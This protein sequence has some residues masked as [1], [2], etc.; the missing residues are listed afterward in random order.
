MPA[1]LPAGILRRVSSL[2]TRPAPGAVGAR[3][4]RPVLVVGSALADLILAVPDLPR[5]G[6]HTWAEP[7]AESNGGTG[8]NVLRAVAALGTV[9][10][11]ALAVGSGLRGERIAQE[12]RALGAALPDGAPSLLPLHPGDNGLCL[13]LLTPDGERTFV[14]TPGCEMDWSAP[15]LAA[16]DDVLASAP[17][18]APLRPVVYASGFQLLARGH[19]LMT[20]LEGRDA[21]VVVD[22]GGRVADLAA[23][24]ALRRR[25]LARTD[26]LA[27]NEEEADTL[28]AAD[29]GAPATAPERLDALAR[30][31]TATGTDVVLRQGAEG[32]TWVPAD[33][34]GVLSA[35]AVPV[36]VVDTDGAGDAHTAGV[37]VG[38]A[39]SLPPAQMLALAN[40]SAARVVA[41]RG[42]QGL[43]A[44]DA[45]GGAQKAETTR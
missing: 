1:R 11:S 39:R 4:E 41:G 35:P 37:L 9:P 31:A 3:D 44:R 5:R 22:P 8:L 13:T 18:A 26:V 21:T 32:A 24:A 23:D 25:L 19:H 20:W 42:P 2:R 38:L 34:T 30:L 40:A 14:T 27:A 45:Q 16:L 6:G 7:V 28:L 12:V 17:E 10:L 36:E 43:V 15:R 33:G 29:L